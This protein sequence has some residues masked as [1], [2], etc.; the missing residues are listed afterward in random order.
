LLC[1]L[2][3]ATGST[4]LAACGGDDDDEAAI[5]AGDGTDDG[6]DD[7]T[8]PDAA[9]VACSSQMFEK[10]GQDAFLAVNDAIIAAS[11]AAPTA[12][13]GTS[14]QDLAAA[15]E[16]R[17]AEFTANLAAFLVFVYGGPNNYTGPS[18]EDAHEGL[19][20]TSEQYDY[21]VTDII[22][23]VLT[24]AGVSEDDITDCFAPPVVDPAFKA[25]I[26]GL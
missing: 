5:D 25:S 18:M 13:V 1:A 22:V 3:L 23:P 20:I 26:V 6:A 19:N 24:E 16:E 8:E 9:P 17:V 14:F 10:Y 7:G 12:M 4:G 2:A 15:G 21:F 11:V